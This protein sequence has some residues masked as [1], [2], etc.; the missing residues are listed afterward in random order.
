ME[1]SLHPESTLGDSALE[2]YTCGCKNVFQL[3]FVPADADGVVV[4]ICRDVCLHAAS[5]RDSNQWQIDQWQPLV[6]NKSLLSWLARPPTPADIKSGP[7]RDLALKKIRNLEVYWRSS[8]I[9]DA[10]SALTALMLEECVEKV[11]I[12]FTSAEHYR[13]VFEPLISLESEYSRLTRY[14]YIQRETSISWDVSSHRTRVAIFAFAS[15]RFAEQHSLVEGK[16]TPGDR[17]LIS[18]P[19]WKPPASTNSAA[20]TSA[21]TNNSSASQK[22]SSTRNQKAE[23]Q[24]IIDSDEEDAITN[25]TLRRQTA[26]APPANSRD[27]SSPVTLGT[28]SIAGTLLRVTRNGDLVVDLEVDSSSQEG[29]WNSGTSNG[30]HVQFLW[31]EASHER[32]RA[33]L[34]TFVQDSRSISANLY[35][36]LL[37]ISPPAPPPPPLPLPPAICTSIPG[38]ADLNHFQR[39]A[40]QSA[41]LNNITLIQ[42]PPGTGKTTTSA[43][44][45]YEMSRQLSYAHMNGLTNRRG[46]VLVVAPSNIAADHLA[47]RICRT[48]LV[49]VRL[50]SKSKET[51]I[52]EDLALLGDNAPATGSALAL[53]LNNLLRTIE[54]E[55]LVK[56]MNT[57]RRRLKALGSLPLRQRSHLRALEKKTTTAVLKS[58]DVVVTTCSASADPRLK[59]FRFKHVLVDECAQATEVECL[60]PLVKG[61]R[62]IVLVGD[63]CQLCPVVLSPRAASAGFAQSLFERLVHLGIRPHRLEVQYRMHPALAAFPSSAFYDGALQNGVTVME[64]TFPTYT[65]GWPS[66]TKPMYFY[67][68]STSEEISGAGVSFINRGEANVVE[69]IVSHFVKEGVSGKSI[70]II[71]PYGGQR[72]YIVQCLIRAAKAAESIS[73]AWANNLTEVEVASVDAFQG[74]E[75]D[76]IVLSC[77]RSNDT[78]TIGFLADARRLNVALT[79][80]KFGLVVIGN[81][82]ALAAAN[83]KGAG[84]GP[85]ANDSAN[86]TDN[87]AGTGH[88]WLNL[89]NHFKRD[90]LIVEGNVKAL[91]PC[92]LHF[93]RAVHL[94]S[95]YTSASINLETAGGSHLGTGPGD[96][97]VSANTLTG[98]EVEDVHEAVKLQGEMNNSSGSSFVIGTVVDAAAK[99]AAAMKLSVLDGYG[100]SALQAGNLPY[101]SNERESRNSNNNNNNK[102]SSTVATGI[103]PV[104]SVTSKQAGVPS[105]F[106]VGTSTDEGRMAA[107]ST[108]ETALGG[109]NDLLIPGEGVDGGLL[110][111]FTFG[112]GF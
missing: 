102:V 98:G 29:P 6:E 85:H 33:A 41:L 80:A 91:V 47:E 79:R 111:T 101:F 38:L 18:H 74:R 72:S 4:L 20:N 88:V 89:L 54:D 21:N 14:Q 96:A 112:S 87:S 103:A 43:A 27:G 16:P 61:A 45:V 11:P 52:E 76:F 15:D 2:C 107:W 92:P 57:L 81:A 59:D 58:A 84:T 13:S 64:R 56:E 86:R 60:I 95:R 90:D 3:G 70:G 71:T 94:P 37:G 42:G 17:I 25:N 9:Q 28:W 104:A 78:K 5:T 32:M 66:V 105:G 97:L 48:G 19:T 36:T 49:V 12:S 24:L 75:K 53:T 26:N 23:R 31:R 44:V 39:V 77:V 62:Q 73:S 109:S 46:Q 110:D 68:C 93:A 22:L 108:I 83:L 1:M 69:K 65:L 106:T 63:H 55:A 34:R 40:V 100:S 82:R 99:V 35:D 7:H 30:F 8:N 50:C 10:P 67:H 51:A